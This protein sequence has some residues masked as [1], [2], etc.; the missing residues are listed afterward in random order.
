MLKAVSRDPP[1]KK[2]KL[3]E[4]EM[5]DWIE[6]ERKDPANV[7]HFRQLTVLSN[8]KVSF[9]K[10]MYMKTGFL[11]P[12]ILPFLLLQPLAACSQQPSINFDKVNSLQLLN[13]KPPRAKAGKDGSERIVI[14]QLLSGPKSGTNGKDGKAGPDLRADISSIN[15]ADT[16][17][18][19]LII[20]QKPGRL[21]TDTFYVNPRYGQVK[22]V[23]DG[24]DGGNGGRGEADG[25]SPG[26]GGKGGP[27]GQI[28]VVFD[29]GSAGYANCRCLVFSNEG[30]K[31]GW[32][33]ENYGGYAAPGIK[34]PPIYLKDQSGKVLLSR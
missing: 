33:G 17:L 30:G 19:R 16:N 2:S 32:S 11:F 22:L 18:L 34:G 23:A 28:E 3:P 13:F 27:G 21:K 31:G 14:L 15:I 6:A 9:Q 12:A 7:F 4:Q 8:K 20:T 25:G 29:A 1:G 24:G 10:A 26:S 5:K